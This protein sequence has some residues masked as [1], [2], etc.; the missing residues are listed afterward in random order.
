MRFAS[1]A[2]LAAAIRQPSVAAQTRA[3]VVRAGAAATPKL[4]VATNANASAL[5]AMLTGNGVTIANASY[6][7]AGA[8]AGTF[9]GA[10]ASIGIDI[11]VVLSTGDAADVAGPN[12]DTARSTDNE[13]PA[14]RR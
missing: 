5:A 7:G 6:R 14:T 8:A 1:F 13:G 2:I 4:G 9:S 11:G 3:P 10:Q 12:S